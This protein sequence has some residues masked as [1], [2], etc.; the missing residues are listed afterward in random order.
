VTALVMAVSALAA[1]IL[2]LGR[3]LQAWRALLGLRHSWLSREILAFGV[4][5][6]AGLLYAAALA[7][8]GGTAPHAG[9]LG[10][11]AAATGAAAVGA[12]AKLYAAT[13]RRWWSFPR[14][15]GRFMLTAANG[16]V[17]L[18][19]AIVTLA[20][21][22]TGQPVAGDVARLA[23]GASLLAVV[24]LGAEVA[25]LRRHAGPADDEIA[26]TAR[27]LVRRLGGL[28]AL[29]VAGAVV[30]GVAP[31]LAW[32]MLTVPKTSATA[33]AVTCLLGAAAVVTGE[34]AERWRFFAAS[35][36]R[37]MPGARP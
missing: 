17:A 30:G 33:A 1:S 31:W 19:L 4:F 27:L 21:A 29:R 20:G 18:L 32:R 12:S 25:L 13:G 35:A 6:P 7:D 16:G 3:P 5:A 34:L 8:V 10:V 15:M 2:H 9:W 23:A 11:G 26:T 36:P 28:V 37:R 14:T 24:T 22:A